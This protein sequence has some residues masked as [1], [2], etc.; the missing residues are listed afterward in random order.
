[1]KLLYFSIIVTFIYAQDRYRCPEEATRDDRP[2]LETFYESPSGH[3]LIHYDTNGDNAPDLLDENLNT[4]PD[5]IEEAA[6]AADAARYVLTEQMGYIQENDDTDGKYD[7]YI[8]ELSSNLWGQTQYE[9]DESTF[10]KIRNSYDGMSSFCDN[11]NDLLWLTI[12]H[13]FFHA[14][15]YSYKSSSNDSY[16]RELTSMWFENIFVP[17]CYD[18]LDF[19][20]MSSSSLFNNPD[21]AF[22]HSTLGSYGY[23]L[24]LFAHYLSTITDSLG[25]G[26]QLNSNII[27]EV[28]ED[29]SQGSS[30]QT[31]FKS[32][33]D[34]LQDNYDASFPYAWS[35]FMSRNMFCGVYDHMDN[36]IYYHNGQ[37]LI[38]P[39]NFDY[40]SSFSSEVEIYSIDIDE[41][42]VSFLGIDTDMQMSIIANFSNGEYYLWSGFF[43]D[44][45]SL[46]N[47]SGYTTFD[48]NLI[49]ESS[50]LFF[51]F[52]NINGA[53]TISI[54]L[55]INIEGCTDIYADNYNQ[56]ATI[57]DNLCEYSNQLFSIYPNPVN[58]SSNFLSFDYIS[59]S[60]KSIEISIFDLKGNNIK[61][62][63]PILVSQGINQVEIS[64]MKN[65]PSGN[66]FLLIDNSLKLRFTNIK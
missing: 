24:S 31:I 16:F 50:K 27:R 40:E 36:N 12:G 25:S 15:Q 66:Y 11:L 26:S 3:F 63:S 8:L 59:S 28:W 55:S 64:S 51:M 62:L 17:E 43:F 57:D 47:I 48:I 38:D 41:D 52:S 60:S 9:S 18:F 53:E 39:P 37:M 30:S 19:V 49:N 44:D 14:I 61:E 20:D 34:V 46:N 33:K 45:F 10:I 21:N 5:Y 6:L 1:M 35:D 7:I 2:E 32:L 58:L 54:D 22:D 65:L 23:S 13:E 56:F 29:Y 42:R 4:I